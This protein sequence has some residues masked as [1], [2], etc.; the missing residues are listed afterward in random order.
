MHGDIGCVARL[1]LRYLCRIPLLQI[2]IRSSPNCYKRRQFSLRI[3]NSAIWIDCWCMVTS[4]WL[5]T[6]L[7]VDNSRPHSH[8]CHS[9]NIG[10][11]CLRTHRRTQALRN[12]IVELTYE[13]WCLGPPLRMY[14]IRPNE[15]VQEQAQAEPAHEEGAQICANQGCHRHKTQSTCI[16]HLFRRFFGPPSLSL[17]GLSDMDGSG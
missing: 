11:T 7:D 16:A 8:S 2:I 13:E 5:G 6:D 3:S 9:Q 15:G 4:C 1:N 12:S 17:R 14:R 10:Y